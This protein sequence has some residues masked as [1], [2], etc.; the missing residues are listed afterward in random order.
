VWIKPGPNA[1]VVLEATP[2]HLLPSPSAVE[3]T[4]S[5][6][7]VP[8]DEGWYLVEVVRSFG[9]CQEEG[10][11]TI[12]SPS[13]AS[14]AKLSDAD[15]NKYFFDPNGESVIRWSP[16]SESESSPLYFQ[17]R[18]E[19]HS[20]CYPTLADGTQSTRDSCSSVRSELGGY[21]AQQR[22]V[23]GY[24]DGPW[25]EATRAGSHAALDTYGVSGS[26]TPFNMPS[27][28]LCYQDKVYGASGECIH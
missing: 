28:I 26:T 18:S 5:V 12:E 16:S 21:T 20:K 1:P 7:D 19:F 6:P 15:I 22:F 4:E 10:W 17:M 23:S 25:Y 24:A 13:Q 27:A 9:H 3:E 8:V 11:R 2:L 14:P